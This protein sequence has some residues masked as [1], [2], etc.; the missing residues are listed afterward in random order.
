MPKKK[1]GTNKRPPGPKPETLKIEGAWE[2][3]VADALKRGKPTKPSDP[4][5]PK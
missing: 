3:A 4:K 2:D 5:P 1:K